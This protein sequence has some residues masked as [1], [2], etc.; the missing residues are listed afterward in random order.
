MLGVLFGQTHAYESEFA[1]VQRKLKP[2]ENPADNTNL[3]RVYKPEKP[4]DS[5]TCTEILTMFGLA[6]KIRAA[7]LEAWEEAGMTPT[8]EELKT[9]DCGKNGGLSRQH[10]RRRLQKL[11]DCG[12]VVRVRLECLPR[13]LAG[14]SYKRALKMGL[15]TPLSS[16]DEG[17]KKRL[18]RRS[19]K[20]VGVFL[21]ARP[22]PAKAEV[23][24]VAVDVYCDPANPSGINGEFAGFREIFP[25][26]P[27]AD[28]ALAPAI[29]GHPDVVAALNVFCVAR[30]EV[31]Q[32]VDRLV[33]IQHEAAQGEH[34]PALQPAGDTPTPA[35]SPVPRA[36]PAVNPTSDA[37]NRG[38]IVSTNGP[39]G[40]TA[41]EPFSEVHLVQA[42]MRTYCHP[43]HVEEPM[44]RDLLAGCRKLAPSCRIG[45][46]V[47][48]IHRKGAMMRK[49]DHAGR[50]AGLN[51]AKYSNPPAFLRAAVPKMF[52][53]DD[54]KQLEEQT[55]RRIQIAREVLADPSAQQYERLRAREFLAEEGET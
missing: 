36:S 49:R 41:G 14:L 16:L 32:V 7:A 24:K 8:P 50:D 44:A 19:G 10:I 28:R 18:G 5:P 43:V 9:V 21:L 47:E 12:L 40:S 4:G 2:H 35:A 20:K 52:A 55:R 34:P 33:A 53:G 48:M 42:A 39:V 22:T 26:L 30:S 51:A 1:V 54:W 11:E 27:R 6:Q 45:T 25:F 29:V 37:T 13:Q 15:V 38:A 17:E 46:V 23:L 31:Q 3:V